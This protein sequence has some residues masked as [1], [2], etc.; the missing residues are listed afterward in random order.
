V[1]TN[2]HSK[3]YPGGAGHT[4]SVAALALFCLLPLWPGSATA[5]DDQQ[6][7]LSVRPSICV[8]YNSDEPCTMAVQARWQ[9]SDPAD[10]CLR[11]GQGVPLLQCWED[12]DNGS[13]ELE[14]SSS[15]DGL[16]QLIEEAS[17]GVLA[18]TEIKVIN[19]DLRSSRKR[20]R[21]VWSIL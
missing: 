14:Y 13:V 15:V 6:Y 19:R 8:S 10:V 16:Y 2:K 7:T 3:Q 9:G 20:R 11:E 4:R 21:H 1:P 18:E 17:L 5:Q 12:S